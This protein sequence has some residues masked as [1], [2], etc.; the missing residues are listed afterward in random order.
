MSGFQGL[1]TLV[2]CPRCDKTPL[3]ATGDG[4]KCG[5]CKTGFPSVGGIPWLF[6]EPEAALGE[7]R[8][9]LHFA[10]QKLARDAEN[11]AAELKDEGLGALT[12]RRLTLQRTAADDHRNRLRELLAPLDVHSSPASY[13]TYL[14]LRTRLPADQGIATYYANVHRDWCWGEEENRASLEVVLD[15]AA[16]GEFGKVLV[17]GAG[18]GRLAYDIHMATDAECT[19]AMDFNPLLALVARRVTGGESL[20]LYE[21]PLA[22]RTLEDVAKL[23]TLAAP[24]A[25][26]DGFHLVLADALRPPFASQSFDTVVTPWL[27][28]I[29]DDDLPDQAARINN[30]LGEGGSWINFG[31]LAFDHASRRRCYSRE[32]TLEVIGS[33]GF[34]APEALDREIPY[35]CSPSSRHARRETVFAFAARKTGGVER[36]A[37]H[38]ALPD[39]LVTG[40]DPVPLT[41]SF[42]SQAMAT[43]IHAYIMALIDGKRSMRDMADILEQQ[44]LLTRDEALP[45]LRNFLK[46]MY[47][48]SRKGAA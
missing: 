42:R 20:A 24:E 40:K 38:K 8:N 30:L 14:A 5:G 11:M 28:D 44:K 17:L 47:E 13:E 31:S 26:R 34:D 35:M 19:I 36:P 21:F 32:E 41:P 22:A 23:R 9:R 25:V 27:I 4:L 33:S 2:A 7:W 18:A 43:R 37:R 48:D 29:L 16:D 3:A 15:L 45:A 6:A 39:W 10:L 46:K 1:S 12:R